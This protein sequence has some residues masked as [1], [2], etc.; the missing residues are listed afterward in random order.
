MNN[1]ELN[2][3]SEELIK[4]NYELRLASV[5][6]SKTTVT[7]LDLHTGEYFEFTMPDQFLA[8]T[9]FLF[10]AEHM[11]DMLSTGVNTID[12]EY[13]APEFMHDENEWEPGHYFIGMKLLDGTIRVFSHDDPRHPWEHNPCIHRAT[14][15]DFSEYG[16]LPEDISDDE[17][18]F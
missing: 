15:E 14:N 16:E 6:I 11:E 1:H 9:L 2:Y 18:P 5:V 17:M 8:E 13:D 7:H 10:F 4:H 12:V 3:L